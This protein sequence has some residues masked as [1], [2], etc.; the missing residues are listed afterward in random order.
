MYVPIHDFSVEKYIIYGAPRIKEAKT[1]S[2]REWERVAKPWI[3]KVKERV[4]VTYESSAAPYSDKITGLVG[5]YYDIVQAT[6]KNQY[7]EVVVPTYQKLQPRIVNA[8]DQSAR[9]MQERA[10]PYGQWLLQIAVTFVRKSVWPPIRIV[11]GE[12]VRPQLVKIRERLASYRDGKK[13]EAAVEEVVTPMTGPNMP[14]RERRSTSSR[15]PTSETSFTESTHASAEISS[16]IEPTASVRQTS[17]QVAENVLEDL[18]V[19][20]ARFTKALSEGADGLRNRI[21]TI[22]DAQISGQAEGTGEALITRLQE[23]T[24][25]AIAQVK[26]EIVLTIAS[27]EGEETQD[28]TTDN[29]AQAKEKSLNAI[30]SAGRKVKE[31]AEKLRSWRS[32]YNEETN[33]LLTAAAESTLDVVD[34]IREAGLQEIGMRWAGKEGVT[35][36]HWTEYHGLRKSFDEWRKTLQDVVHEHSGPVRARKAGEEV[37]D[38]GMAIAEDA[39]RELAR[40]KEV[41]GWKVD[42]R[43]ASDDFSTRFTPP[44]AA[45]AAQ[46]AADAMNVQSANAASGVISGASSSISSATDA[47]KSAASSATSRESSKIDPGIDSSS[48]R[49]STSRRSSG[50]ADDSPIHVD[51]SLTESIG[52]TIKGA[53]S[54]NIASASSKASSATDVIRDTVASVSSHISSSAASMYNEAA[55]DTSAR[56]ESSSS[57]VSDSLSLDPSESRFDDDAD[58]TK[59]RVIRADTEYGR[60]LIEADKARNK[61]RQAMESGNTRSAGSSQSSGI[62]E[63]EHPMHASGTIKPGSDSSDT[64]ATAGQPSSSLASVINEA[65]QD[66]AKITSSVDRA[67]Q[68]RRGVES[69]DGRGRESPVEKMRSA[70]DRDA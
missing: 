38:R 10:L 49:D 63:N 70:I 64:I 25:S 13:L 28:S 48:D 7:E 24:K 35:Y 61:A 56:S 68:L 69:A 51:V 32:S 58:V 22:S 6:I 40:L 44:G 3:E 54:S 15:R 26:K 50:S 20:K 37:E 65:G 47:V 46:R 67:E 60:S 12:N 34:S 17:T 41:A 29:A 23:T 66:Y 33:G 11:Y 31:A 62:E 30:R 39:A 18:E 14:T 43:D 19:W 4:V 52:S 55:K 36:A 59:Q 53:M 5:P 27:L 21:G 2:Q 45:R 16:T 8:Y 9:F 57:S 1:Y 42:A